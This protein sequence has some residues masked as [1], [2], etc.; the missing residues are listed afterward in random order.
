MARRGV[1]RMGKEWVD[2]SCQRWFSTTTSLLIKPLLTWNP[3]GI[4]VTPPETYYPAITLFGST[5]LNA[6]SAN[7]DTELSF[8]LHTRSPVL[9]HRLGE[10][11]RCLWKD[12]R[13]VGVREWIEDRR[14]VPLGTRLLVDYIVGPML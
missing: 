9:Q 3:A 1:E 11:M 10:E 6:R 8:L 14:K 13:T 2:V 5:N 12:S 4:W 7:L